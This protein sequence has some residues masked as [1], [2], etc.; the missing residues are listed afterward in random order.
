VLQ[1]EQYHSATLFQQ[2]FRTNYGKE[3]HTGKSTYEW[4]KSFAGEEEF[5]QATK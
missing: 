1:F 5:W 3:A 2:W 4:H